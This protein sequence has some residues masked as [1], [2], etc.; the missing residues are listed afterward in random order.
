MGRKW[1][2]VRQRIMFFAIFFFL[3]L[4]LLFFP[5]FNKNITVCLCFVNGNACAYACAKP[6]RTCTLAVCSHEEGL[7][8]FCKRQCGC[9]H[10]GVNGLL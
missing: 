4:F 7:V 6:E 5:F 9:V 8:L 1:L 2:L 10:V 3:H